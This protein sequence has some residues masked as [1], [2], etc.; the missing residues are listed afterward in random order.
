VIIKFTI[1]KDGHLEGIE[2]EQSSRIAMLDRAAERAVHLA[3]PLPMLPNSYPRDRVGV[4]LQFLY[5]NQ[6][7][8][9]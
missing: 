5:S 1:F 2:V 7:D 6:N 8:D 9:A 3:N 4:H